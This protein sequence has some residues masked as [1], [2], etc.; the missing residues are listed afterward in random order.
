MLDEGADKMTATG[1]ATQM[2]LPNTPTL[3]KRLNPEAVQ[4]LSH[5][6]GCGAASVGH[7]PTARVPRDVA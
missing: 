1:Q 5:F 3:A 7:S 6:L 4:T 2:P